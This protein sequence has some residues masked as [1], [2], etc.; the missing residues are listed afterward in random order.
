MLS[1]N[2]NSKLAFG[3]SKEQNDKLIYHGGEKHFYGREGGKGPGGYQ[4]DMTYDS[5]KTNHLNLAPPK[6]DR[7]LLRNTKAEA[8]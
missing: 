2:N 6:A 8:V 4:P 1:K 5:R 3:S 7:G